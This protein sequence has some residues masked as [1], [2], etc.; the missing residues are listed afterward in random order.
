LEIR[1]SSGRAPTDPT[2]KRALEMA[3]RT[4]TGKL[5]AKDRAERAKAMVAA[6]PK[7]VQMA[8]EAIEYETAMLERAN[9]AE[10]DMVPETEM[11]D[12]TAQAA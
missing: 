12:E 3:A 11:V 8:K 2:A 10:E 7:W 5:T 1:E 4:I 9:E 6:S